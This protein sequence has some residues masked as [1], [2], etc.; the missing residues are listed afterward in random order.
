M[1]EPVTR[2]SKTTTDHFVYVIASGWDRVKIGHSRA[3]EG[4]LSELQVGSP[5]PL[6][7]AHRWRADRS[8]AKLLERQL[9]AAFAWAWR[10]GE[11]FGI[12]AHPVIAAGDFFIGGES[13]RGARVADLFRLMSDNLAEQAALRRAWYGPRLAKDRRAAEAAARARLPQAERE[14]ALLMVEALELGMPPLP[15]DRYLEKRAGGAL[16]RYRALAAT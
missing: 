1:V 8:A 6:R 5:D 2:R 7:L 13:E 15:D 12:A 9:H 4:R 16:E 10:R 14:H 3:P 11:W